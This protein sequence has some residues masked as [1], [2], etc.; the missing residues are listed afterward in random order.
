MRSVRASAQ[1][2]ISAGWSCFVGRHGT[3]SFGTKVRLA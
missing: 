2:A 1:T 3:R